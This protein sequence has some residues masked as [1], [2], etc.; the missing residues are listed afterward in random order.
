LRRLNEAHRDATRVSGRL[1]NRRT[2]VSPIFCTR[3][4][5]SNTNVIILFPSLFWFFGKNHSASNKLDSLRLII[6]LAYNYYFNYPH[7]AKIINCY[8]RYYM[9][10]IILST[11]G[12]VCLFLFDLVQIYKKRT[13]SAIFSI[14]GYTSI[15][16]TIIFLLFSCELTY[17]IETGF[18]LFT[19]IVK[20]IG[21]IFFFFLLLYSNFIEIGLKSPYSDSNERDA[22]SSGSYGLVRHPGFL[23]LLLVLI[24]LVLIYKHTQFTLISMYM[25]AMNFILILIEDIILF[26]RIFN[27]YREYKKEV[28]FIIPRIRKVLRP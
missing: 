7:L 21:A 18:A 25:I 6:S 15:V 23:W 17:S 20:I 26:P 24:M 4:S 3:T 5:V 27:N 2:S 19:L 9:T 11:T 22:L 1:N 28:P 14:I 12:F 16:S 13:L 10:P 8:T